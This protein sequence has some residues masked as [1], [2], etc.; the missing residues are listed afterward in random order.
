MKNIKSFIYVCIAA[1]LVLGITACQEPLAY[2]TPIGL[3]ATVDKTD[4]MIGE[5]F[6]P[7]TA[8]VVVTY[9]DNSTKTFKGSELAYE[10]NSDGTVTTDL[11]I[12]E[13]SY[14]VFK[15][16]VVDADG[17]PVLSNKAAVNGHE[18]VS[19]ELAN[20]PTTATI[21]T[22]ASTTN[23]IADADLQK[24]TGVVTLDNGL[25]REVSAA[26][27]LTVKGT[28]NDGTAVTTATKDVKVEYKA[29]IYSQN[30]DVKAPAEGY[31]INVVADA[32][33]DK[34]F[35]EEA[36]TYYLA[37]VYTIGGE[38]VDPTSDDDTFYLGQKL[39]WKVVVK[40]S[41]GADAATKD[42]DKSVFVA[43]DNADV[44]WNSVDIGRKREGAGEDATS[45][46]WTLKY[47]GDYNVGEGDTV[48]VTIP[49]GVNYIK[50]VSF[51]GLDPEYEPKEGKLDITSADVLNFDVVYGAEF[52]EGD[53]AWDQKSN[54]K[55]VKTG[56]DT[57]VADKPFETNIYFTWK[58]IEGKTQV[59]YA[60]IKISKV[61][62]AGA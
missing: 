54:V 4:Y 31:K 7:S 19:I 2:K 37:V 14:V 59:D 16:G 53:T 50:S 3:T 57:M 36:T 46:S 56:T 26:D 12:K 34:D 62:V 47:I 25:T 9:S 39:D 52:V 13:D 8:S 18:A 58:D 1:V 40:D 49:Y 5:E 32:G 27:G 33:T 61:A 35:N 45:Y 41:N 55:L 23:E 20:L 17:T 28:I 30:P 29:T 11:T 10:F 6:D 24:I 15:Y 51:N 60:N 38:T 21:K 22:G 48:T 42:L 43:M 44:K